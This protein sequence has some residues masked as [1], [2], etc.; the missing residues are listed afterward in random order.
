M[1]VGLL[2]EMF[3]LICEK[4]YERGGQLFW[5]FFRH[6]VPTVYAGASQSKLGLSLLN[7][8][9][10]SV[11]LFENIYGPIAYQHDN[12]RAYLG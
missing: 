2:R 12:S 8:E 3:L 9:N 5:S 11:D 1:G 4:R 6:M 7:C 10:V